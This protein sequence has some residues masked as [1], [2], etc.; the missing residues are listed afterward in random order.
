MPPRSNMPASSTAASQLSIAA[1]PN[2][3]FGSVPEPVR[4]IV[5]ANLGNIVFFKIDQ[6]LYS[7]VI[8]PLSKGMPKMFQRN[9]E[10]IS[11]FFAYL[12][13]VG[14][15]HFL[16]AVLVYGLDTIATTEKYLQ[17]LALTYSS[18]SFSLVGSTIGNSILIKNGVPKNVA[19]WGTIIGFG[20]INF[21]L[22]K[23][24]M[25]KSSAE[26]NDISPVHNK[27][28]GARKKVQSKQ[29]PRG[30]KGELLNTR[31]GHQACSN[32]GICW[33]DTVSDILFKRPA[34][35][36]LIEFLQKIEKYD[37][38]RY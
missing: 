17:T 6:I 35:D 28:K 21:F 29:I 10:T 8:L 22:L 12:M 5:S 14:V 25:G 34:A 15:Q 4:F 36:P 37:K 7:M 1:I 20:V 3:W 19:F 18:Y 9:K 33:K 16:N 23:F 11:F 24:L 26:D 27:T 13:Q 30:R 2:R 38:H 32:I 31:G